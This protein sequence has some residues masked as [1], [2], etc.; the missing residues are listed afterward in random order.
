MNGAKNLP[1]RR[2]QNKIIILLLFSAKSSLVDRLSNLLRHAVEN[3]F[4]LLL[5]LLN[6]KLDNRVI[7]WMGD[8]VVAVVVVILLTLRQRR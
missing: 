3:S 8:D 4:W 5:L 7:G 2:T 1:M 6:V